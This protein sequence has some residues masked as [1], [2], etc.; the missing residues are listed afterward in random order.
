MLAAAGQTTGLVP[1]AV[2]AGL[3]AAIRGEAAELDTTKG[4]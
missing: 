3:A 4:T 2:M 1:P